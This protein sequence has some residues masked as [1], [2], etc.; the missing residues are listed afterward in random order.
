MGAKVKQFVIINIEQKI[1]LSNSNFDSEKNILASFNYFSKYSLIKRQMCNV[2]LTF[3]RK[4]LTKYLN[5]TSSCLAPD[6]VIQIDTTPLT[7]A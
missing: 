6:E 5:L 3:V 2:D 1:G 4:D 7:Q